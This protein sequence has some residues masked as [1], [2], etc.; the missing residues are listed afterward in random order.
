[1]NTAIDTTTGDKAIITYLRQAFEDCEQIAA[2]NPTDK[3]VARLLTALHDQFDVWMRDDQGHKDLIGP[4]SG[5][6]PPCA[7]PTGRERKSRK[8]Q[9]RSSERRLYSVMK[10]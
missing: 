5:Y 6:L 10:K 8:S 4:R 9:G 1:M 2:D 7:G 3:N